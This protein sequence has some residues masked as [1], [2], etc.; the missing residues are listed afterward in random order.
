MTTFDFNEEIS[1][2]DWR[3]RY[4]TEFQVALQQMYEQCATL[5]QQCSELNNKLSNTNGI[6]SLNKKSCHT[7]TLLNGEVKPWKVQQ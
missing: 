3:M 1:L 5:S 2:T 7:T 6:V 4:K